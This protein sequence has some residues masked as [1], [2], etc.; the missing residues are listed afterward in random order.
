M[1][2]IIYTILTITW[3]IVIFLFSNQNADN[4][5]DLS[6]SFIDNTIVKIYEVFNKDAT[7]TDKMIVRESFSMPVRKI[8][9]FSVYFVL[10]ILVFLTFNEYGF[11]KNWIIYY[12]ILFC[13]MYAVSD[14]IHQFIEGRSGELKDIV[15][16]T[17]GSMSSIFLIK[18]R[19]IKGEK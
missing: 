14:E 17:L 10:G 13:L 15:I 11:N 8:A 19:V 6:N 9:H 1:K 12:A 2:K 5:G 3:M 16:D 4:S 7:E 18:N